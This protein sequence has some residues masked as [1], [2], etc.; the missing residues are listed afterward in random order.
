[1]ND[2]TRDALK[3]KDNP[4]ILDIRDMRV[5]VRTDAGDGAGSGR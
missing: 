3:T 2:Q 5:A 1:M 4:I